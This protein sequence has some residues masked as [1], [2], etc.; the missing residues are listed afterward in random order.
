MLDGTDGINTQRYESKITIDKHGHAAR[1]VISGRRGIEQT[2]R[3]LKDELLLEANRN[4]GK[5]R[6]AEARTGEGEQTDFVLFADAGG[7]REDQFGWGFGNTHTEESGVGAIAHREMMAL[8][9]LA[10]EVLPIFAGFRSEGG[11]LKKLELEGAAQVRRSGEAVDELAKS[12]LEGEGVPGLRGL[13]RASGR[14]DKREQQAQ[15]RNC[16]TGKK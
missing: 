6:G 8:E 10:E 16:G 9:L 5:T 13:R 15:Q 12:T 3:S 14:K 7:G 4:D 11:I 1:G 2:I